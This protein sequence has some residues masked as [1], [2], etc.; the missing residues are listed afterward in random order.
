M[1][2]NEKQFLAE[3]DRALKKIPREVRVDMLSDYR[4]HFAIGKEEGKKEEEI[5]RALG[6]PQKMA[7]ELLATYHLE[8]A[9]S[10][11]TTGN[12]L[13]AVW[14]GIG[15]GFFNLIIVLGPFIALAAVVVSGWVVGGAFIASPLLALVDNIIF[16]GPFDWFSFFFSFVLCGLGIFI[17]IG[18]Y[19]LTRVFS[20]WFMRYLK[21][22]ASFV[23]GGLNHES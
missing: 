23:K 5:S 3:L 2:M 10:D 15:I 1:K 13:R 16:S 9:K 18:M 4:E 12:V 17:I 22:N 14:A 19:H 6:S 21:F 20:K 8:K 7:K 11:T